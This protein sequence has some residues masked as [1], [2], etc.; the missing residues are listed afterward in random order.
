M[1]Q[2]KLI[3]FSA[4]SGAGK[5]TIVKYLLSTDLPIA[6]SIS[7]ASREKRAGETDGKDY[8]FIKP[9]A[10][11][12]KIKKNEFLEWEEVYENHFYGTLKSEVQRIWDEGKHVVFDV[13]VVGGLNIKKFYGDKALAI[14]VKPPSFEELEK[15]LRA[16]STESEESLKKR[17]TKANHELTYSHKFDTIL[18]NDKIEEAKKNAYDLV[19]SF[20][21]TLPGS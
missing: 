18:V 6:F 11:K 5:T 10:F 8:Y 12:E 17:L 19:S 13:D 3:I 15:R 1:K 21:N 14:F 4:P 20:V 9:E 16:R 7:A 2:G